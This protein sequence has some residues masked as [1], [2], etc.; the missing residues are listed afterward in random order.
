[1]NRYLSN[2]RTGKKVQFYEQIFF[3]CQQF[4]GGQPKRSTKHCGQLDKWSFCPISSATASG[5][6]DYT[7]ILQAAYDRAVVL[8]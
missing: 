8:K 1:L 6:K 3:P 5:N 2:A 7:W 4:V